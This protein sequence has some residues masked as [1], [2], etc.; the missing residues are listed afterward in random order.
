MV[1]DIRFK[2]RRHMEEVLELDVKEG[3]GGLSPA[4]FQLREVLK[5]EVNHLAQMEEC[6][7]R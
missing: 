4:D 2:K 1:G 3:C 6:S 7:W 5:T